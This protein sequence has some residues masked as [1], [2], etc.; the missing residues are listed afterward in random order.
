M[1]CIIGLV[2]TTYLAGFERRGIETG[3]SHLVRCQID[4][5]LKETPLG[6]Q[7]CCFTQNHGHQKVVEV[8]KR[9][10]GMFIA[11]LQKMNRCS[12]FI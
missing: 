12:K 2:S 8:Q 6:C 5:N 3:I 10:K 7:K 9:Q 4:R 11:R 1:H